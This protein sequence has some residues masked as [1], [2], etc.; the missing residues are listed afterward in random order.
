M[1]RI[2]DI[3]QEILSVNPI[4]TET[5]LQKTIESELSKRHYINGP[6]NEELDGLEERYLKE[7]EQIAA[8]IAEK[9][10]NE[11]K[12]ETTEESEPKEV[13]VDD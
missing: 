10:A 9:K 3:K 6:L 5:E 7:V 11:K 12:E 13:T 2:D 4:M 1:Q 8:Q